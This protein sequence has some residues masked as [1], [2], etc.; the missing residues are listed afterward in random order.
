MSQ[1]RVGSYNCACFYFAWAGCHRP[2]TASD[3]EHN[4]D[5]RSKLETRV[6][7]IFARPYVKSLEGRKAGFRLQNCGRGG[8]RVRRERRWREPYLENTT[9]DKRSGRSQNDP[10]EH[11][12]FGKQNRS[13]HYCRSCSTSTWR[14]LQW[15]CSNSCYFSLIGAHARQVQQLCAQ[16]SYSSLRCSSWLLH[17]PLRHGDTAPP[18]SAADR[19][20]SKLKTTEGR[21]PLSQV[22]DERTSTLPGCRCQY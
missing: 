8:G 18:I 10:N 5:A 15:L 13:Y 12:C 14:S 19:S 1:R 20:R 21:L 6:Q 7:T 22:A 17:Q 9:S 3:I 4:L 2:T 11:K 16:R